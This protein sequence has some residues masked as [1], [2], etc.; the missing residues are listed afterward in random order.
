MAKPTITVPSFYQGYV[1]LVEEDNL[2]QALI[3]N[4]NESLERFRSI[5]EQSGNYAYANGKWTIKEVLAH[6]IDAERVF[7]YRA[8]RFARNDKTELPGYE[9]N[10]YT[11]ESNAGSRKLYKICEEFAN[12]RASTIDLF[13]SFDEEMLSRSGIAS[14]G[15]MSVAAL[16]YI[17]VGHE[18]HHNK[19]LL[20]RYLSN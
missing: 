3:V 16:G 4:G 19:I 8:L 13:G 11:P 10:D 15:E 9:E 12:L 5:P 1:D 18:L 17:I 20:E 7:A 6:I 2:I 14:G